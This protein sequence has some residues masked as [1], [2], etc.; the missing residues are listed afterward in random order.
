MSYFISSHH[1]AHYHLGLRGICPETSQLIP[2]DGVENYTG[3]AKQSPAYPRVLK[4]VSY[5]EIVL[6]KLDYSTAFQNMRMIAEASG[7][8]LGDCLRLVV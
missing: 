1:N 7:A 4:G 6:H 2:M 8:S 5:F 3:N